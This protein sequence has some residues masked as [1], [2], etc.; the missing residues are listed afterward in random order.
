MYICIITSSSSYGREY[1]VNTRSALK[2]AAMYGRCEGG[3]IV[4]V[5]RKNGRVI[6]EARYINNEYINVVPCND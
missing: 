5:T 3:E 1:S 6:S 4:R 2:C